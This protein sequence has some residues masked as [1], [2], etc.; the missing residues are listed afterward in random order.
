MERVLEPELMNDRHQAKVYSEA[1]FNDSETNFMKRLEQ[2]LCRYN[3]ETDKIELVVDLGC[4]PGKICELLVKRW[5]NV[6]VI[7][8]DGAESMLRIANSRKQDFLEKEASNR[9]FYYNYQLKEL[10][11]P[12]E[13]ILKIPDLVVSNS[14]IHHIHNIDLF[15]Q[16]VKTISTKGTFHFHRDLRRPDTFDDAILLQK[17][18]LPEA[19]KVLIRDYLASLQ[20]SFTIKELNQQLENE[21]LN[22]FNV[23]TQGDQYVDIAGAYI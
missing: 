2:L 20:A 13:K 11:T 9:I 6:T 12:F 8:I 23:S 16:V 15:W 5:A 4:G 14:L 17:K 19:P 22:Y 3:I 10:T 21:Q 1:D 18:Y 7:G